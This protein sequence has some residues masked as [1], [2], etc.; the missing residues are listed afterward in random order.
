L[1]AFLH[2]SKEDIDTAQKHTAY[3]VCFVGCGQK[4]A[5]LA[6]AF[7]EAGFKVKCT[8]A[9][10]SITRRLSK[11]NFKLGSREAETN[12]KRFVRAEQITASS[13]VKATV[14][15]SDIVLVMVNARLDRKRCADS[16][17]VESICKQVGAAL[18]KGCLVIY[19]GVG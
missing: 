18:P 9:D 5:F 3:T 13:D 14:A 6:L 8:D 11:G 7:A 4:S 19:G 17:E 15:A 10:Q 1:P 2:I 16:S 12:L